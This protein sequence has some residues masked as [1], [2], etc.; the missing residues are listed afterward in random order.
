MRSGRNLEM[1]SAC[2][3]RGCARRMGCMSGRPQHRP[4]SYAGWGTTPQEYEE[5]QDDHEVRADADLQI[6]ILLI[7][8]FI[9]FRLEKSCN[10]FP[11]SSTYPEQNDT[12]TV[13][14]PALQ[15]RRET[16]G[17][18]RKANSTVT[19]HYHQLLVQMKRHWTIDSTIRDIVYG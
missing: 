4:T 14:C 13:H 6:I 3:I 8:L 7:L 5:K 18:W 11:P 19:T 16:E 12:L 9:Y 17:L 15:H 1:S 10:R 2:H